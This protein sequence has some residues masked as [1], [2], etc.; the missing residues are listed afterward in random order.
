MGP[1][2]PFSKSSGS[3]ILQSLRDSFKKDQSCTLSLLCRKFWKLQHWA[4]KQ[5]RYLSCDVSSCSCAGTPSG[6]SL[7]RTPEIIVA[8]LCVQRGQQARG[9]RPDTSYT[10]SSTASRLVSCHCPDSLKRPL[11]RVLDSVHS[12]LLCRRSLNYIKLLVRTSVVLFHISG[13]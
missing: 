10:C 8:C 12:V 2:R 11:S 13:T 1:L 7:R 3:C 5:S 4:Q 6:A 9:E